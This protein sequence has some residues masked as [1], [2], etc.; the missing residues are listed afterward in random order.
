MAQ[1]ARRRKRQRGY[2]EELK[3][4]ALRVKVYAGRDPVSKR[5]VYLSEVVPAGP[6]G[7]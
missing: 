3:S 1:A 4:G 5:D 7:H 2:I 6:K